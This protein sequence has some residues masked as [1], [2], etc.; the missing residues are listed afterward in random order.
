MSVDNA[1]STNEF[2]FTSTS[3]FRPLYTERNALTTFVHV[4]PRMLFQDRSSL[5]AWIQANERE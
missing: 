1:A 4:H 2:E 3:T 5:L